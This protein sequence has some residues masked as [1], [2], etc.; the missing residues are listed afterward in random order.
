MTENSLK[1]ELKR[2]K[3]TPNTNNL[4]ILS[5]KRTLNFALVGNPNSGKTTLF[6]QLTGSSQYVGNWPG[7]TVEKKEGTLR[8]KNQT[9]NIIDLPGIYSLSPYSQ[10]EVV[11][12]SY[13]TCEAPDLIINIVDATNIERNL[14]LTT[15]LVE[16]GIPIVIALNMIDVVEKRG[17]VINFETLQKR[18][19][20]PVFPISA[21]KDAGIEPLIDFA[22][23][24]SKKNYRVTP[25]NIYS[26]DLNYVLKEIE[27]EIAADLLPESID[28]RW[29]AVKIFEGDAL[30]LKEFKF[31]EE[32]LRKFRAY[33]DKIPTNKYTNQE[34]IIADQRYAYICA[35]CKD[36]LVKNTRTKTSISDR[37]DQVLTHRFFA[38]PIFLAL[39]LA[40]FFITFGPFGEFFKSAAESLI[41]HRLTP[42][43]QGQ[44][45]TFG[46]S[47]WAKSLVIDGII[48]GIGAVLSF[49]PQIIILFTLLSVLEDSG[50]MA[51][52]AF[53][54]DY[55]LRKLG[56]SGKAFVPMLMGFGCTVPAVMGTRTLENPRDRRLTVMLVPFMSCSAKMPVYALFISAFFAEFKPLVIF[57]IYLLGI[58]L[59]VLTAYFFKNTALSGGGASFIMELPEYRFPTAKGL[60]LHV[61]EKVKDFLTKAGTVLLSASI[62]IWFLQSFNPQ[63][64]LTADKSQS[65]LAELGQIIAPVFTLCGFGDWRAT[66]A[67]I[68]G[69]AAKESVVSTMAILYGA[70][71]GDTLSQALSQAFSPISAYAFMIFVLLYTPCVAALSAISRELGSKKWT[72]FAIVFQLGVAWFA[73]ALFFQVATI[74]ARL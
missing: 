38:I 20:V 74:F 69:L 46:A 59:A 29:L 28:K 65:I 67:L 31:S 42:F 36:A 5:A 12:R 41:H 72:A 7:V 16:L 35:V 37:I 4:H 48:A 25:Q 27:R 3:I 63:L 51:R 49:L 32:Q 66:V 53:I 26:K 45:S 40:I 52:A 10:E 61:W 15:Q 47:D 2:K 54:M 11:T 55:P 44:L 70:G 30:T 71:A 21:S 57:S 14:Y 24:F 9:V 64:Q 22:I 19:G 33:R 68:T 60:W 39:V 13:L 56:L 43:V 8:Y 34:M 17:D 62:I 58:A 18:L 50:Y 73:S 6:N 23:K 1:N